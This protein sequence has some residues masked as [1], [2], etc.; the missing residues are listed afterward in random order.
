MYFS[1]FSRVGAFTRV[2]RSSTAGKLLGKLASKLEIVGAQFLE[3][4]SSIYNF[5]SSCSYNAF[6]ILSRSLPAAIPPVCT[7]T[8]GDLTD[9]SFLRNPYF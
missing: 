1:N 4:N 8:R 6:G 2:L 3:N 5:E 7:T 9:I